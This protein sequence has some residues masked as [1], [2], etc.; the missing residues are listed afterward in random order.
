MARVPLLDGRDPAIA[1]L[2]RHLSASRGGRLI[3]LYRAL[4]HAPPVASAW[5]DFNTAIRYEGTLPP[6]IVE[7]VILRV[8]ALNGADY[9]FRVHGPAHALKAGLRVEQVEAVREAQLAPGLF[10]AAQLAALDCATE[11]TRSLEP[12]E[13]TWAAMRSHYDAR[14]QVELVVLASAYN[15]HTRVA[16][17]LQLE[18]EAPAPLPPKA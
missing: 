14:Q 7:L 6:G 18:Q 10:D 11:I 3:N 17:S 12:A 13:A 16:R 9:Q 8:A 1:D 15:M 2:A 5:L 4:L